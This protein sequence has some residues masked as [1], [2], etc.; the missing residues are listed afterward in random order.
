MDPHDSL[1]VGMFWGGVLMASVPI[2]LVLGVGAFVLR[3]YL[4]QRKEEVEGESEQA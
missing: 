1:M 3:Y 4:R 2:F